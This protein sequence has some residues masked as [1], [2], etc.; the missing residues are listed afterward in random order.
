MDTLTMFQ[1]AQ[2]GLSL[3]QKPSEN[4]Y[5]NTHISKV[6]HYETTL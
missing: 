2:I 1:E 5:G 3:Q 4:V 6:R